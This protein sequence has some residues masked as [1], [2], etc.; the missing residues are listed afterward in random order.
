MKALLLIGVIVMFGCGSPMDTS[1]DPSMDGGDPGKD[2]GHG[3]GCSSS[4]TAGASMCMNGNVSTCVTQ[5]SGCRG[6][7]TPVSCGAGNACGTDGAC[8]CAIG[9]YACASGCCAYEVDD[10]ALG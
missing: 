5:A 4:C 1:P 10:G 9:Q 8:A 2:D 3:S 7:S 6:W